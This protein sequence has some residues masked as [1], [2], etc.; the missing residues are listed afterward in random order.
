LANAAGI[1]FVLAKALNALK[2]K[3]IEE[4]VKLRRAEIK[5]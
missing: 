5:I 3:I 2:S 1:L 4:R